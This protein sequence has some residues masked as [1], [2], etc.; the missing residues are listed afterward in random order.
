MPKLT[1]L[2]FILALSIGSIA[3]LPRP[4]AEGLDR[5]SSADASADATCGDQ[6]NAL[7][8]RA[9]DALNHGDRHGAVASLFAAKAQLRICEERE[10]RNST[11]AVA[12]AMNCR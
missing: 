7:L 6:Y 10:E 8:T 3:S 2:A 12:I 5:I 11:A 4:C 1:S 9:K